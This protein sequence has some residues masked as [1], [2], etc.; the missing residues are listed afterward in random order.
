MR[1]RN[2]QDQISK[3]ELEKNDDM[4]KLK[5]VD[6]LAALK[7]ALD[8][9]K[10]FNIKYHT[11]DKGGLISKSTILSRDDLKKLKDIENTIYV[12]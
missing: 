9:D 4:W 5:N 8:K 3:D 11:L 6:N 1:C 2:R 10:A 7:K 12:D